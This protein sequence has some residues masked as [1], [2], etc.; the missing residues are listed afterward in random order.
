MPFACL[1]HEHIILLQCYSALP[2]C[3]VSVLPS[4]FILKNTSRV[5]LSHSFFDDKL[6]LKLNFQ[7]TKMTK[8]M[9]F[10]VQGMQG[11]IQLK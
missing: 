6:M 8:M 1:E 7:N 2:Q 10:V 4:C 3:N 5:Q 11:I 9:Y